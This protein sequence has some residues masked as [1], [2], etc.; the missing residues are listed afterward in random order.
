VS[1][2]KRSPNHAILPDTNN[3]VV[4]LE[5]LDCM[6]NNS[7]HTCEELIRTTANARTINALSETT[8]TS[9]LNCS[10]IGILIAVALSYIS[11]LNRPFDG[12]L[13]VTI[14]PP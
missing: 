10:L 7:V 13:G 11:I 5:P 12:I 14:F 9:R 4:T 8:R 3:E 1:N 6:S 2:E